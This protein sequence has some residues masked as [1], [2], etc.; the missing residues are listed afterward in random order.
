VHRL[1]VAVSGEGQAALVAFNGTSQIEN[2]LSESREYRE[3]V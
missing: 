1:A 2:A 3:A